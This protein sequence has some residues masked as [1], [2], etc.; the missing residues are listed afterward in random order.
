M[1]YY[2]ETYTEEK[3]KLRK[4]FSIPEDRTI[5]ITA[6]GLK[7]RTG[8]D[9]LILA[10]AQLK[11]E[12]I[13]FF[14][15]IVGKGP[16]K[17][18]IERSIKVL[19]LE[20]NTKLL[21]DLSEATLAHYYSAS[22]AFI[23]PTQGAEAFGLATTEAISAGLVALGTNNG[24][25]PEILS[26]Y[27]SNWIIPGKDEISIYKKMKEYCENPEKY[28]I[29]LDKMQEVTRSHYSW[30]QVAKTFLEGCQL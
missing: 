24:G 12:A 10:T 19:N 17:Q 27:N 22:D 13:P 11:K 7:G 14:L 8:V 20:S 2:S 1:N 26:K 9:K 4:S 5:F 18:Q 21:S 28:S 29:P 23:L 25:T 15:I 16:M 6:R 3:S 30:P